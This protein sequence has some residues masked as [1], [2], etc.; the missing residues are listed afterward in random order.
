M[1]VKNTFLRFISYFCE[2]KNKVSLYEKHNLQDNDL[3]FIYKERVI[4]PTGGMF[5]SSNWHE[6]I[7][8][9]YI[10]DGEGAVSDN[11]QIFTVSKGD[12]NVINPNHLHTLA[13]DD[14]E[15]LHRYL[16][17]DRAFCLANGLDTNDFSFTARISDERVRD[18]M[19]ELHYAYA[20]DA[21]NP[22]RTLSIR[23]AV[24]RLMLLLAEN[25]SC[26]SQPSERTERRASYVKKAIDYIRASYAKNFSLEDVATFVGVNK[27]YLSREFHKYTGYPF[28]SYVNRTRCKMACRLLMDGR[29]SICEVGQ[30][31]GF[32]NRSYFAKSFL[33]YVGVRP[34]EYRASLR[35]SST[36]E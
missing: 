15:M 27:C 29:L 32:E 31:C 5:G 6:N 21:T 33:K 18:L 16:I 4:K 22:L 10:V 20:L 23:S 13:A 11:G 30:R 17:V 14:G 28:V 2:R 1:I 8:I 3:P 24:L 19:E 34:G 12:I 25:Y 36:K 35:K 26:P 7:E 9:I